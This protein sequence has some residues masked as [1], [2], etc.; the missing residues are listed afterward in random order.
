MAASFINDLANFIQCI[1]TSEG[2]EGSCCSI[3]KQQ[4]DCPDMKI[5]GSKK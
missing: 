2:L 5:L 3:T 1:W 4:Q